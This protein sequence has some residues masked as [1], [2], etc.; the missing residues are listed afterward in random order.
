MNKIRIAVV[1]YGNIGQHAV[2][3]ILSA[4]DMELAGIIRREGA[5]N[6]PLHGVTFIDEAQDIA[7]LGKV[8]VALLCK[9]TRQIEAYAARYLSQG[10]HTVDSF[11]IHSAIADL[12]R[13]LDSVAKKGNATAIISAG[14]D[15]GSDS[16]VRAL[17]EAAAPIGITYTNF[18]PGLSMGHSVVA[19]SKEGVA[20]AL[21]ITIPLGTSVH[22]RMVYVQLEAGADLEAVTKAIKSDDYFKNDETHIIPVPDVSVLADKGHGVNMIRKGRSGSSDNQLFTFEMKINNP[23][24]TAQVMV[25]CA[26][27]CTR[28]RPG[29]YTMVEVPVIDLLPGDREAIISRL[30]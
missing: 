28:Q 10:I 18:G 14:W 8:D 9:P 17:L 11:D 22:R 15:P 26:R 2:E 20:D 4:P 30:V 21:S 6:Q 27:A 19:R 16:V 29:A 5:K 23:A 7:A 3:A 1:G 25:S 12:R 13:S 24:L